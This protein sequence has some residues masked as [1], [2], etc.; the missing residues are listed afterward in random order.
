MIRPSMV[1]E[2]AA[3]HVFKAQRPSCRVAHLLPG[4]V[5]LILDGPHSGLRLA[6]QLASHPDVTEVRWVEAARS[7]TVRHDPGRAFSEIARELEPD[8][9]MPAPITIVKTSGVAVP[10]FFGLLIEVLVGAEL[11]LILRLLAAGL[12]MRRRFAS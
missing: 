5:R 9:A 1:G 2:P 6:R 4:R 12:S 11:S 7:L 10:S 8:P 3:L